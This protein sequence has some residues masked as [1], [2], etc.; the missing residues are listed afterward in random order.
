VFLRQY[1]LYNF[2]LDIILIK[3]Q[4]PIKIKYNLFCLIVSLTETLVFIV[5]ELIMPECCM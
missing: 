4:T 5:L 3:Y 2:C 1:F